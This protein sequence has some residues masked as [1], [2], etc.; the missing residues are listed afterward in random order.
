MFDDAE[1][2]IFR[3]AGM[4]PVFFGETLIG[5]NMPNLTYMLAYDD[6]DARDKVWKHVRRG[7]RMAEA[8]LD[9]GAYRSRRLC[10]TSVTRLLRPLPFSPIQ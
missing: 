4:L 8:S 5:K 6:W 10:R 9:A 2:K 3:R 7:S 1:I